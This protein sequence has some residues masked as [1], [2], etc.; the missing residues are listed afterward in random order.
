MSVCD[1][2]AMGIYIS[3]PEVHR[4]LTTL[5]PTHQIIEGKCVI[6][7]GV[8]PFVSKQ[9]TG[10][11]LWP[12]VVTQHATATIPEQPAGST[13]NVYDEYLCTYVSS[14]V[15][16]I[17]VS[18]ARILPI[19]NI[20]GQFLYVIAGCNY[21]ADVSEEYCFLRSRDSSHVIWQYLEY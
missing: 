3:Y 4:E 15:A 7:H 5:L 11:R 18:V 19:I 2:E 12:Y 9:S 6:I 13:F 8:G 17:S 10:I 1:A 21:F 14:T 20:T 16:Q